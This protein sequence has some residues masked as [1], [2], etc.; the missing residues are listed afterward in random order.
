MTIIGALPVTLQNGTTADA[1]DVMSDLNKIRSDTNS[2]A[3]ANG[4]NSDITSLTG[5]TTPLSGAQ[6]G[7]APLASGTVSA[8]AT[9]DIVLTAYTAFRGL[10]FILSGFLPA[11]D[12]ALLYMLFSTN[13]G[14]SYIG[15]GYNY[16]RALATDTNSLVSAGSGSANQIII[17]GACGNAATEG[18]N[19][20][21]LM[22][23]QTSTAFWP[24]VTFSSYYI[25]N[26]GTP[27][28]NY[29][30]GGGANE[31]AIDVDAVR[32]LFSSGN[33]AEGKYAVYGLL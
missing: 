19:T 6:G 17:T 10:R 2:N 24:R 12:G 25:D 7:T 22:L 9:L 26:Q 4:A 3:A 29:I 28:G 8:A 23:N 13:G 18:T 11:T 33:I 1:T 5:L 20:E 30:A 21:I 32:F 27:G 15:S 14:S 16:G 31:S